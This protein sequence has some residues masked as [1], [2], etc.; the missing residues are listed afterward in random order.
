M[1]NGK[2]KLRHSL[3][4]S[5]SSIKQCIV[6]FTVVKAGEDAGIAGFAL[7]FLNRLSDIVRVQTYPITTVNSHLLTHNIHININIYKYIINIYRERH[8]PGQGM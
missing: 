7:G 4:L 1:R 3:R 2:L 6:T 5:Q 8:R